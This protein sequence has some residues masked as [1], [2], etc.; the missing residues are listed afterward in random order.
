MARWSYRRE[1]RFPGTLDR[2]LTA[3][4]VRWR[5]IRDQCA[6]VRSPVTLTE[7]LPPRLRFA[8]NPIKI[9]VAQVRF[10]PVWALAEPGT[11]ATIQRRLRDD[12]PE[13]LAHEQQMQFVLGNSDPP[14]I[15]QGPARFRSADARWIVSIG[16]ES[17]SLE[18]TDYPH[19]E[20]F[21]DR[22]DRVL[23]SVEEFLP[24]E[25]TRLGLRYVNELSHRDAEKAVDWAPLLNPGMTALSAG[26]WIGL[27]VR[28]SHQQLSLAVDDDRI[29]LRH[30]FIGKDQLPADAPASVYLIDIDVFGERVLHVD[31]AQLLT[32][33]DRYHLHAWSLFRGCISDVLIEALGGEPL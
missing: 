16:Q 4:I 21:R 13:A 18:T 10:T 6:K 24:E 28:R 22:L 9:V 26:E 31:R 8:T 12:Y 27:H 1:R 19:W 11:L 15:S 17:V 25:A 20:Q 23:Q 14:V 29:T 3:H 2:V 7:Q 5:K 30:G 32:A 33:L